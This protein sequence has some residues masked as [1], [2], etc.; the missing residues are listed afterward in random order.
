M[1]REQLEVFAHRL[2]EEMER[3]REERNFFQLER[4]K[5]RTFWEITRQQLEECQAALRLRHHSSLVLFA[6]KERL[7]V[8][9]DSMHTRTEV[10]TNFSRRRRWAVGMEGGGSQLSGDDW[11]DNRN[12]DRE[13]EEDEEKHQVE[14]K[15][16]K[17]KVKH[18][19]YEHQNNLSE[20]KV[21]S[22]VGLKLAQDDYTEQ[23]LE[24]L[25]D[26]KNLKAKLLEQEL[27]SEEDIKAL[28]MAP[29]P[30][31]H[32]A[33]CGTPLR[34]ALSTKTTEDTKELCMA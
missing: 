6:V 33:L 5:I 16:Y 15:V 18:L 30:P 28:R 24:L 3:E 1:T 31:N 7:V 23:E 14:I 10:G 11:V 20:L 25:R 9:L 2:R 13:I 21:E 34:A 27:A 8:S 29:L 19:M 26:K 22:M 4:D 32:G 17:Q 12:K